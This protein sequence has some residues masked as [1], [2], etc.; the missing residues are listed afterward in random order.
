[1]GWMVAH[2]R[3]ADLY[4]PDAQLAF[5]REVIHS[6]SGL[7]PFIRPPFH[8]LLMA[9]LGLVSLDTAFVFWIAGQIIVL[10]ACWAWG[11][12]RFGP[13]AIVVGAIFMPAALGMAYGQDCVLPLALLIASYA[14]AERERPFAAGALLGGTLMK[15]HLVLLWPIA[16]LIRR[17]WKMLA[18]FTAAA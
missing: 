12:W 10:L 4:N 1:G 7:M 9:P 8:A 2:A 5:Q 18:G 6:S 13:K 3:A 17:Q 14:A 15:F 16:L 11:W